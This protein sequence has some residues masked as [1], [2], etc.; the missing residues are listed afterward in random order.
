MHPAAFCDFYD[1]LKKSSWTYAND[2]VGKG[3]DVPKDI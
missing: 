3:A 2:F 1:A